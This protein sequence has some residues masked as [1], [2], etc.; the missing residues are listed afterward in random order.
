[1]PTVSLELPESQIVEWVK[2]LSPDSQRKILRALIADLDS[3]EST[4]DYGDERIRAVCA[5]RG[6]DWNRLNEDERQS[7]VD[8]L[9]HEN[10][11]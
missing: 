7:L 6:I 5:E 11:A 9:L 2:N 8:D 3:L 10:E 1:M 4:V